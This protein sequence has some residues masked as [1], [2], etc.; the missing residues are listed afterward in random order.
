M[1]DVMYEKSLYVG[2]DCSGHPA[3]NY[4]KLKVSYPKHDLDLHQSWSCK[5]IMYTLCTYVVP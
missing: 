4:T 2:E 1:G 5:D 3:S